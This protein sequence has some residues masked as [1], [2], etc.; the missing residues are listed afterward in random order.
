MSIKSFFPSGILAYIWCK[1]LEGNIWSGTLDLSHQ[2]NCYDEVIIIKLRKFTSCDRYNLLLASCKAP[3]KK[4]CLFSSLA[5]KEP[6][7]CSLASFFVLTPSVLCKT[8]PCL[9]YKNSHRRQI[10]TQCVQVKLLNPSIF[11]VELG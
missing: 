2:G 3:F 10:G 9:L 8:Q 1:L 6:F 11:A 5:N 7:V 4:N